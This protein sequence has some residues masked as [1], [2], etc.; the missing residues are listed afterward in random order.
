MTNSSSTDLLVSVSEVFREDGLLIAVE[1]EPDRYEW[2]TFENRP[3]K[4]VEGSMPPTLGVLLLDGRWVTA[5]ER[6]L[7]VIQS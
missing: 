2:A 6:D 4:R 7:D 1:V 3:A 5:D